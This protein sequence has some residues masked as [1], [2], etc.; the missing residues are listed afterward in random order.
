MLHGS[1]GWRSKKLRAWLDRSK[2]PIPPGAPPDGS[3]LAIQAWNLL[4]GMDWAGLPLVADMLGIE[5]IEMLAAQLATIR[6]F[7]AKK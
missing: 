6:D 1:Q 2:L 4:G 5:D 3:G 7:Q